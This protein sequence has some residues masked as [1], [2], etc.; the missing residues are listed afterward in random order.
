M[1]DWEI[2][3]S[4]HQSVA[5]DLACGLDLDGNRR[6]SASTA[7]RGVDMIVVRD[8]GE[9]LQLAIRRNYRVQRQRQLSGPSQLGLVH[10][11]SRSAVRRLARV[12]HSDLRGQALAGTK[13]LVPAQR[14]RV[15]WSAGRGPLPPDMQWYGRSR[16]RL[17]DLPRWPREA[18]GRL[19]GS[20]C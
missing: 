12:C 15:T 9:E 11:F 8:R 17:L 14:A 3:L 20:R 19:I 13:R 4:F 6:H 2:C 16:R 10:V 18:Q 5:I 1:T 7:G